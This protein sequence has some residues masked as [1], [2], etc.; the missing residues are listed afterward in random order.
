MSALSYVGKVPT[1]AQ[2]VAT[3]LRA[4]QLVAAANPSQVS[5]QTEINTQ[6]ALKAAK[7]YVDGQA[8]LYT[9]PT[10]FQ[11]QDQLNIPQAA[12]GAVNKVNGTPT[13]LPNSAY[14]GAAA[15]DSTG[16][17]PLAQVSPVGAGY[18]L[19]PFGPTAGFNGSTTTTPFKIAD[20]N[21]GIQS[22]TFI[23][24]VFCAL[25]A[26]SAMG[27]PIVEIRM[28]NGSAPYASQ[29]LVA[30]GEGRSCYQSPQVISACSVPGVNGA[31]GP[32]TAN[33]PTMN[34]WLSAWIYDALGQTVTV[35]NNSIVSAP[36]FLMRTAQ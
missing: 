5:A 6:V 7:A 33:P 36:V 12:V 32:G 15:L 13:A 28:S 19:G 23:P 35:A 3:K 11:A 1:D 30:R 20:W 29:T 22:V 27:K 2:G 21:I 9:T 10:Y 24:M 25:L 14:Y 31:T 18:V 34:I 8:S 16:K 26:Q 4:S 17:I